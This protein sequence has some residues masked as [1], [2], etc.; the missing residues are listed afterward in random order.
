MLHIANQIYGRIF[1][2]REDIRGGV[3]I[4]VVLLGGG[5]WFRGRG[6]FLK[7]S[8]RLLHVSHNRYI[9]INESSVL[10]CSNVGELSHLFLF[11][12]FGGESLEIGNGLAVWVRE[13]VSDWLWVSSECYH[14][15]RIINS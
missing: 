2:F 8:G 3:K 14:F 6:G 10:E 15:S 7:K 9:F 4:K 11:F 13:K 1:F 12:F 5:F